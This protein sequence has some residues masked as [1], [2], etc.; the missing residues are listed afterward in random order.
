M[1]TVAAIRRAAGVAGFSSLEVRHLENP[2]VFETYFPG[3]LTA[4]PRGYSRLVHRLG[5]E[6]AFGTLI[7]RLAN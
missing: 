2:A 3:R 7:C 4:I 6:G 1:N 5:L